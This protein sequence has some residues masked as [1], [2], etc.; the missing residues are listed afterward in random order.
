MAYKSKFKGKE[1]DDKLDLVQE[2]SKDISDIKENIKNIVH[3]ETDPVFSNSP[4]ANITD[5]DKTAWNNKQDNIEDLE[6][7]RDGANK[8]ATA[9]QPKSLTNYVSKNDVDA[10]LSKTSTNPIQNKVVNTALEDIVNTFGRVL[11]EKQDT[12]SD[13]E[14]IRDGAAKGVTALQS[15]DVDSEVSET[16]TNPVQNKVVAGAFNEIVGLL[17]ATLSGVDG[18]FDSKQDKLVSGEN[19]KTINGESII[20][21]GNITIEGGSGGGDL[22]GYATEEYVN[23]AVEAVNVKGEDGYVYSNGEKVDMR[24]TRSLIPVGTSIPA[25]ANLNTV[26]YLKVGKY[27]CSLSAD[28]KTITNCPTA[29]AFMMEVFNPL[30]TVVDNEVNSTYVYRIRILTE[31][32][33]GIQYVQYCTVGSTVNKWTYNSWYVCPRTKFTLNSSKND[34]SA[35]IG[36]KT[37]G[38]YVDSTGTLQK[39]TYALNKTVPSNAVFTDTDTK[40]TAVGNH[41]TPTEDESVAIEA[42]GGEVIIGLKRD[43]AGHVVGVM[44]TPMSGG[45]GGGGIAVE[46]DP[47]FL[48]SPAASITDEKMIGWDNKQD[49]I[50][51]L[52]TIRSNA[53]KGATAVQPEG[54]KNVARLD[55]E[56]VVANGLVSNDDVY[57]HLPDTN[58]SD[59]AHTLAT[60]DDVSSAIETYLADFTYSQLWQAMNNGSDVICDMQSL[61]EAMRANKIILV[62][63]NEDQSYKGVYVLTGYA[64]DLLYFSIVNAYGSILCCEGTTYSYDGDYVNFI[65]WRSLSHRHW[66]DKQD[67]LESGANIK[68]INGESILGEGDIVFNQ[69]DWNESDET[70]S[71]Y[72]KNRTH[73][74]SFNRIEIP[75]TISTTTWTYINIPNSAGSTIYVKYTFLGKVQSAILT[76]NNL[77][78]EKEFNGGPRFIVTRTTSS[79]GIKG[80]YDE[81]HILEVSTNVTQLPE[82]FIPNSIARTSKLSTVATSGS[83]NDLTDKPTVPSDIAETYTTKFDVYDLFI[84]NTVDNIE[85]YNLVQAIGD[86][87][88]I[89]VPFDKNTPALGKLVAIAYVE[90]YIYMTV[91]DAPYLYMLEISQ[92]VNTLYADAITKMELQPILRSGENIKTING[93]SI[94]GSGNIT[95]SGGGGASGSAQLPARYISSNVAQSLAISSGEV[96][97]FSTPQTEGVIFMLSTVD[98]ESG[99][100]SAWVIRFT[101]GADNTGA[102]EVWTEDNFSIKWANGIAPTFENGKMYELSFR[103]LGSYFLGVWASF[104]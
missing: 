91:I 63:E 71:A 46:N 44:S 97:I 42:P 26:D 39:M 29:N 13:L 2:L 58:T 32:S 52:E 67:K 31:Y 94:L 30:S 17:D 66:D 14:T 7:I 62:R 40:V 96:T 49:A 80:F 53:S 1:I 24:F 87:K 50:V 90:D 3:E 81:G 88:I 4:A 10:E 70:S 38:V 56:Y 22:S 78:V 18:R 76:M 84:G 68:T 92:Y 5:Q 28:A 34:G 89:L 51:D 99:K 98:M 27:Y 79:I 36:A 69:A 83:Y 41:Y 20:G 25:K 43:A 100:D 54:I 35:A 65:D 12:I 64:E 95:I 16:S 102:Y 47:I 19:I 55:D 59:T 9:I 57:Y 48:A 72:V 60:K 37:Q 103:K 74:A 86:G 93:E 82:F 33:T 8:G 85:T 101:I 11:S 104:E 15:S 23:N 45:G 75:K 73:Y 21:E 77:Y 61:I 6:A